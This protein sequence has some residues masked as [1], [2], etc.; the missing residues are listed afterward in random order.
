VAK[1]ALAAPCW[2]SN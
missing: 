2:H 1:N